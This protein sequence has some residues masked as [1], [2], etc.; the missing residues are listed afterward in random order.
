M[1]RM[2]RPIQLSLVAL[3]LSG[4]STSKPIRYYTIQTPLVPALSASSQPVSLLVAGINSPE[5]FRLLPIVYRSG[6]NEIGTY[7]YSQWAEPPVEM[8]QGNLIRVLRSTGD[9]ESVA[10][11]G[12]TSNGR[13]VIRGRL[14]DF[15]EVDGT[16]ITALVS[17]EFELDDRRSGKVVWSHLYSRS[18]PVQ[19]KDMSAIVAALDINLDRGLKE[20]AA[21]LNQYFSAN[22]IGRS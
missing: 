17:M 11:L 7:Q 21:G 2:F 22:P 5:M 14:D 6:T 19:S 18:E 4:C 10:S 16:S 13:F 12:S 3:I 8:V 9:Y 20:V 15:E 1:S